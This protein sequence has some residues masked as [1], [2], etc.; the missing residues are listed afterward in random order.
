MLHAWTGKSRQG[1]LTMK[2]NPKMLLNLT[3]CTV[4]SDVN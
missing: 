3:Q 4:S 1:I 2:P